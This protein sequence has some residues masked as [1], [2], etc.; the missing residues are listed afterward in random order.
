MGCNCSSRSKERLKN[1]I[2]NRLFEVEQLKATRL[3][4]SQN[5]TLLTDTQLLDYHEKTHAL[6]EGNINRKK[7]NKKLTDFIFDLHNTSVQEMLKRQID[8]QTPLNKI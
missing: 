5:P 8:H 2:K 3:M 4:K 1:N 6:Y 7:I